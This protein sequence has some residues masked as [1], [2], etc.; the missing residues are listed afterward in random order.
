[1]YPRLEF[2]ILWIEVSVY[3]FWLTL[4]VCFFLFSWMLKKLSR[5]VGINISFFFNRMIWFFLSVVLFSRLFYVISVWNDMKY[6]KDPV[7]F[8]VMSDYN[9]S[10]YGAL[11]GFFLI[12]MYSLKANKLKSDKYVD[13][14]VL[15]FL[16]VSSIGYLGAFFW[17][18]VYGKATNIG[19]EVL[20]NHPYSQV[21]SAVAILPLPLIYA[22]STFLLFSALYTLFMLINV[23]G[24]VWYIGLIAFNA[25][26]L[27]WDNFSWKYDIIKTSTLHMNMNQ[28]LAIIFILFSAYKLILLIK[29]QPSKTEVIS[30]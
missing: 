13:V 21:P 11:F 1:M 28:A 9:F 2:E 20:Y 26:V 8:F 29:N 7:E 3:V 24:L 25:M 12:L 19:I 4:V 10:L 30:A 18:Q 22:V 14:S 23:R 5:K 15:S 27:V 16:F 6:I 17:W